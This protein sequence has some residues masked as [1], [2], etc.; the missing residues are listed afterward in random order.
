MHYFITTTRSIQKKFVFSLHCINWKHNQC[1]CHR[2]HNYCN[3]I[4]M[5]TN[6]RDTLTLFIYVLLCF[7]ELGKLNSWNRTL[8]WVFFR[9]Y[10]SFKFFMCTKLY[11]NKSISH[12]QQFTRMMSL[13]F[14]FYYYF[15]LFSNVISVSKNEIKYA[16]WTCSK[17][18]TNS[19]IFSILIAS[20]KKVEAIACTDAI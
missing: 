6:I 11:T 18:H 16:I 14:F 5:K 13:L 10:F 8:W 4:L 12:I 19:H 9:F 7:H 17:Q 2:I 15:G 1:H 3:V 20:A